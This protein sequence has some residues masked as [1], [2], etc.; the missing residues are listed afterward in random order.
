MAG[1]DYRRNDQVKFV[2][3]YNFVRLSKDTT[4]RTNM[5][6]YSENAEKLVTG[7]LHCALST[8]T[9][10]A[11]PD[12]ESVEKDIDNHPTFSFYSVDGK[13]RIPGSTIRG[14]IRS[15]YETLTDSC[16]VTMAEDMWLTNRVNPGNAYKPGL[17]IKE[18][19]KWVLYEAERLCVR[20]KGENASFTDGVDEK[21]GERYIKQKKDNQRFCWGASVFI[22]PNDI[23]NKRGRKFVTH[24]EHATKNDDTAKSDRYYVYVGEP[25]GDRK[26]HQSVF[27]KKKKKSSNIEVPMKRLEY[28]WQIYDK[29]KSMGKGLEDHHTGYA[30][31]ERAKKGGVVP[32]WY[33]SEGASYSLS[34]A[35]IGRKVYS[36]SV[37]DMI[38]EHRTPCQNRQKVCP[39]CQLFGMAKDEGIGSRIRIS[40]ASIVNEGIST[41]VM[42]KELGSPRTGY[43]PFYSEN[44][45]EFDKQN[46]MISGRKYYWHIPD[47]AKDTSIYTELNPKKKSERNA[48]VE[49]LSD[50]VFEFDVYFDRISPVQLEE[51]KWVLTLGENCKDGILCH[52]I[53]HGKPLGLGSVK[54]TIL[55][56]CI[57]QFDENRNYSIESVK[58]PQIEI[59]EDMIKFQAYAR[60]QILAVC[61]FDRMEGQR[62]CYPFIDL[63]G[64][65]ASDFSTENSVASHQWFSNNKSEKFNMQILHKVTDVNQDL[66]AYTFGKYNTSKEQTERSNIQKISVGKIFEGTV[67]KPKNN[68]QYYLV[69]LKGGKTV[70]IWNGDHKFAEGDSI[71]VIYKGKKT[72]KDGKQYDQW[73][74]Q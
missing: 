65:D 22:K 9:P 31:Y 30:G 69:E 62:V 16:F 29:Y 23:L 45:L 53:G 3:P 47:A 52:K 17:L 46:A 68:P 1:K 57:R 64:R 56:E 12:T 36:D 6:D 59:K 5:P 51:L 49:L 63:G 28:A 24:M 15:I 26:K 60:K 18:E 43:Y 66:F 74:R 40:D 67:L 55:E 38:G 42:L 72:G 34:F 54:M 44:G 32:I 71:K 20:I 58:F 70:S 10:L 37:N 2:N 25:F 33:K 21:S 14:C 41:S 4:E 35:A 19:N 50:A 39:A 11:I 73:E 13:K 27:M 8:K 61:T 7:K 48:T